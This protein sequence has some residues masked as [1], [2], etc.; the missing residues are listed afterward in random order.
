[1]SAVGQAAG[2][3]WIAKGKKV[4][5]D[6]GN[7]AENR[8]RGSRKGGNGDVLVGRNVRGRATIFKGAILLMINIGN[9]DKEC[10]TQPERAGEGDEKDKS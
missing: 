9:P 3:E 4:E 2:V 10:L 1:M 6:G 5:R 7:G 8:F